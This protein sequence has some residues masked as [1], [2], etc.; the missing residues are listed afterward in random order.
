MSFAGSTDTASIGIDSPVSSSAP[1]TWSTSAGHVSSQ[2]EYTNVT[3]NGRPRYA[4]SETALPSWSCSANGG[5]IAP[6][7]RTNP[8][9][10]VE[11][12]ATPADPSSPREAMKTPATAAA[13]HSV[14]VTRA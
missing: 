12:T 5:A 7:G 6:G 2:V 4:S 1:R 8:A 9:Q 10:P 11:P 14:S 13:A 3:T